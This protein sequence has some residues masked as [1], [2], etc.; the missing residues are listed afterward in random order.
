MDWTQHR[1]YGI[2]VGAVLGALLGAILWSFGTGS[3]MGPWVTLL[4]L[5]AV[6]ANLVV[7]QRMNAAIDRTV[8]QRAQAMA[9]GQV[10]GE[11][12]PARV[13]RV[14]G[15]PLAQSATMLWPG[16]PEPARLALLH[17][18]PAQGA[19]RSVYA[20]VPSRYGLT[21]GTPA[22]VVLDPAYPDIAVFDDRAPVETLA[23]IGADPRWLTE[24]VPS[25][26][27]RQGGLGTLLASVGGLLFAALLGAILH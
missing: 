23:A 25:M 10:P 26:F 7:S 4:L 6:I 19:P 24:R 17:V 27:T 3:R 9:A 22:A 2:V 5:G 11:P 20:V 13:H 15:R 12:A 8:V 14:Y 21:R 16:T 18:L 1:L